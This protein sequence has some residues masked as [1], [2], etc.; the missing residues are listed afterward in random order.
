MPKVPVLYHSMSGNT[1]QMA[2]VAVPKELF[3]QICSGSGHCRPGESD[4]GLVSSMIRSF[5]YAREGLCLLFVQKWLRLLKSRL[6]PRQGASSLRSSQTNTQC[7][8][9]LV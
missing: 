3:A 2:E 1:L 5:G 9:E 4:N 7:L 8:E 6:P